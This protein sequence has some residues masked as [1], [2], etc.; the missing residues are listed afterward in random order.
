MPADPDGG[1]SIDRRETI[2]RRLLQRAATGI[3]RSQ[4]PAPEVPFGRES[5]PNLEFEERQKGSGI[6][7][8]LG[9]L[10][11]FMIVHAVWARLAAS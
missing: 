8:L 3:R 10:S 9:A 6:A 2:V 7:W 5:D 1:D 11:F 4:R